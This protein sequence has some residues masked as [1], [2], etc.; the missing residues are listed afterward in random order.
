[1]GRL[2]IIKSVGGAFGRGVGNGL[3]SRTPSN[4]AI[5]IWLPLYI[6]QRAG[7]VEA[8]K[9]GRESGVL[10]TLVDANVDAAW[11]KVSGR[12]RQGG[13]TSGVVA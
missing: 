10:S 11:T 4:L 13:C 2:T 1:M 12:S 7:R 8:E 6:R 3:E 9:G 5:Y